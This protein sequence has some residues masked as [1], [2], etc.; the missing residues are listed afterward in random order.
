MD[1]KYNSLLDPGN[2]LFAVNEN[3]VIRF[4][5]I[6]IISSQKKINSRFVELES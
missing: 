5:V 2:L 1:P 3:S 4:Y 6:K